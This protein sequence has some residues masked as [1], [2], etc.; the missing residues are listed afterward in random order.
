ML[1]ERIQNALTSAMKAKDT[2]VTSATR[3]IVAGIKNQDVVMRG[4]GLK[5][6]GEED[7]LAMMQTMIKQRKESLKI[8]QDAGRDDKAEIE[9]SEIE[10]IES[11]LPKQLSD[12]EVS[13]VIKEIIA[14]TGATSPKDMGLVMADLKANYVG[15]LD[16][17]KA[18]GT[19]KALLS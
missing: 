10:I 13:A 1:R 12:E 16:F 14:K 2:K 5:E 11:F 3:M 4:K 7:I 9:Q 19:V 15:K 8:Y 6:A 18:S 17:A